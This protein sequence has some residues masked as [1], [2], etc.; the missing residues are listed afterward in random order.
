MTL[1]DEVFGLSREDGVGPE[2]GLGNAKGGRLRRR[3]RSGV[4]I[5]DRRLWMNKEVSERDSELFTRRNSLGL[6]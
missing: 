6:G 2:L 1:T 4:A 3:R 5:I